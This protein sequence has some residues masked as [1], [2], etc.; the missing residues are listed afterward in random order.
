MKRPYQSLLLASL[1]CL[2]AL[3][4]STAVVHAAPQAITMTPTSNSPTVQPGATYQGSFQV[5]DQGAT[6]FNFQVY[7]APYHVDGE[8]YTPDFTVLPTAPN[9]KSWFTFSTSGG[10]INPGQAITVNYTI[11]MPRN[12]PPGG[13]YATI[14]AQTQYPKAANSITLNE[15]VGEIIYLQ[16]A[17]PVAQKGK[18]LTWQS[19]FLQ[20]P[21]LTAKLRLENN[22]GV[23]YPATLQVQVKD[24]FGYAKYSLNTTKEILPQTIRRV[25]IPWQKTP[26]IGLFKVTGNVSFLHQQQTLPTRWVLVMSSKVRLILL[27]IVVVAVIVCIVRWVYRRRSARKPK[28]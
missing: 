7:S 13:Y 6:A 14:F 24:I 15:R 25:T 22:G 11:S 19:N 9:V 20:K 10:H 16:A 8:D 26:N 1:I 18:V 23:H 3:V 17:G 5:V 21:P 4:A 12:T 27:G 28:Q 2:V